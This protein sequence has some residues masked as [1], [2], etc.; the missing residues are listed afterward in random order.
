MVLNAKINV[1]ASTFYI[2]TWRILYSHDTVH[3]DIETTFM[4]AHNAQYTSACIATYNCFL[5]MISDNVNT[6]VYI[7]SL[8]IFVQCMITPY[9]RP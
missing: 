2:N 9:F 3:A 4:K 7:L 8:Y 1:L 6:A 5:L